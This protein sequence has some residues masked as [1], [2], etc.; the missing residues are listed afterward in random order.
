MN[1]K[2][3]K[4]YL[5]HSW[6]TSP[7]K[8]AAEKAYNAQYYAANPD[9]WRINRDKRAKKVTNSLGSSMPTTEIKQ[10]TTS[11][12]VH[13]DYKW[14]W[15]TFEKIGTAIIET[16]KKII[17]AFKQTEIYKNMQRN[18]KIRE[19]GWRWLKEHW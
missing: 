10:T 12:G 17:E 2:Y 11:T 13:P 19:E 7:D 5:R 8:K 14:A 4:D 16:G 6:G 3:Y 9:R 15:Q 1:N 18:A